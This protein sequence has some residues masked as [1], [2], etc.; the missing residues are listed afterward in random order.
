MRW[1]TSA[2]CYKLCKSLLFD[3]FRPHIS[4]KANT[5][6]IACLQDNLPFRHLAK[7]WF[8]SVLIGVTS[9]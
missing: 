5:D 7:Y 3:G 8:E 9:K 6:K 2:I 4:I 1:E